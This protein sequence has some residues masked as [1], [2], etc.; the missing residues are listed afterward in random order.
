MTTL[1]SILKQTPP[2]TS[3]PS[4]EERNRDLALYHAH[5][6][7]QRK[8]VEAII[9]AATETLLDCPQSP[10]SNA[11]NPT[12][13]DAARVKELL[14]N[15]QPSDYDSLIEERGIDGK[16][17]YVLCPRPHRV[18]NTNA[19][20]RIIQGRQ[21]GEDPLKV[22]EKFKLEQWCSEE[23]GRRALYIR[24]QLSEVPAWSRT[25]EVGREIELYGE[26]QNNTISS[27]PSEADIIDVTDKMYQLAV[28]RGDKG[29]YQKLSDTMNVSIQEHTSSSTFTPGPTFTSHVAGQFTPSY[30]S[31]EGY[32]PRREGS[33]TVRSHLKEEESD[34]METI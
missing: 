32:T 3:L 10:Q 11:N 9:F 20:F 4:R 13:E 8:D 23:C 24:V 27:R 29:H 14:R 16:C 17:G 26:G 34:M 15:F 30:N 12:S 7:Q 25:G 6:I 28:E 5:L 22:V 1:K 33:R 31:V 21:K 19:R 2:S 18:E